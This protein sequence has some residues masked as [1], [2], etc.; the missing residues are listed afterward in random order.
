MVNVAAYYLGQKLITG[1]GPTWTWNLPNNFP[2]G[3]YLR[4]T[5]DGGTLKQNG[6]ALP[7]SSHGYYEVSLDEGSLTL[8]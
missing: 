8:E 4:V 6:K 3:H 5:V 1:N 2:T 7:W